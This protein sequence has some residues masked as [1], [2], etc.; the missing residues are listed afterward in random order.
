[1][2]LAD[3]GVVHVSLGTMRLGLYRDSTKIDDFVTWR[4]L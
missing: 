4:I 1:M 3:I 2:K